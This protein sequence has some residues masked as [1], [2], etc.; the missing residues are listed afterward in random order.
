VLP[1]HEAV[2]QSVPDI[3]G[4]LH[5][6]DAHTSRVQGLPSTLQAAPSDLSRSGGHAEAEPVQVS[7]RSQPPAA[8]ARHVDADVRKVSAGQ[9]I[10]VPSHFSTLS[11]TSATA[12][13]VTVFA[14][15]VHVPVDPPTLHA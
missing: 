12:R 6:P 7:A 2:E 13:Q 14:S 11:H 9:A 15:G 10:E 4:V 8:A 1:A 5:V 3:A